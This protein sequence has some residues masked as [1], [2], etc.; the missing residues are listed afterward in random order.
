MA[1]VIYDR[2]DRPS[3]Y[4]VKW[5]DGGKRKFKFFK[6]ITLRN[7]FYKKMSA[8]EKRLGTAIIELSAGEAAIM[9][10]CVD[11]L[12]DSA[13]VL[14]ACQEYSEKTNIINIPTEQAYKQ[15]LEDN[16]NTGK[17]DDYI[18]H[19]RTRVQ[20]LIDFM[21]EDFIEW[22]AE[23]ARNYIEQL[24]NLQGY[25]PLTIRGHLQ[26]FNTF[27]NWLIKRKHIHN[28]PFKD[29]AT[30]AVIMPEPE[31]LS[32]SNMEKLFREA[33]KY[34]PE[35]VAYYALGAFAGVR[36]SACARL[37]LDAIDFRQKG[38]LM[39][40]DQT[41]NKRRVYLD[42]YEG[43]L[44]IWLEWARNNAPEGFQLTKR[45][46]DEKRVRVADKAKVKL[47]HNCL[48]HSFCTYHVAL[49][50]DAGKTATLL[51]HRGNVSI[52]YEHYKGN[53]SRE[54]AEVW[55]GITPENTYKQD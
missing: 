53:A 11:M 33:V 25:K 13:T 45:Q 30:Q 20:R 27:A 46:W 24:R 50:G 9:R 35:T 12:G 22:S 41:K 39:R 52:L 21:P 49:H 32:V 47:P 1:V 26:N 37:G 29:I 23:K 10:T 15:F 2:P 36:S 4:G 34:Y 42:G 3:P 55:F 44:W 18:R 7:E 43:N 31:Y 16:I 5:S 54:D 28:N 6:N 17:S 48:R 14:K 38:I 51:T 40:A 19:I 8:A